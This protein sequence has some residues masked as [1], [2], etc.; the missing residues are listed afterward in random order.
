MKIIGVIDKYPLLR[1]GMVFF[2]QNQFQEATIL[3]ST[4]TEKFLEMYPNH[5]PDLIILGISQN[6]SAFHNMA[7]IKLIKTK[8]KLTSLV[9]YD[10]LPEPDMVLHYLNA[11]IKGY[12]SKRNAM[13]ELKQCLHNVM[14]G[15]RYVSKGIF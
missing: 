8:W 1:K 5:A 15:E 6:N 12:V 13:T 2:I 7:Y 3:E 14:K 10:E 4:T 9:V 11:G